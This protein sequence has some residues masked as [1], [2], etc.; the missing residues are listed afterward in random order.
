MFIF[1]SFIL[2]E[3]YIDKNRV[4]AFG[5]VRIVSVCAFWVQRLTK[6]VHS[7]LKYLCVNMQ[8]LYFRCMEAM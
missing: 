6:I 2:K 3:P 8:L 5:K 7:T 4:G 1:D